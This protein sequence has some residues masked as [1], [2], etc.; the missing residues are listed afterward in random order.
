MQP[1]LYFRFVERTCKDGKRYLRAATPIP[2]V[3]KKCTMCH[4]NYND[5]KADGPIGVLSYTIEVE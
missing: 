1:S 2:V 3:L 5:V 4:D